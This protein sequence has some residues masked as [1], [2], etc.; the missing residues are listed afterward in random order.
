MT[1]AVNRQSAERS[2][3][4]RQRK[5]GYTVWILQRIVLKVA[6]GRW[7]GGFSDLAKMDEKVEI[8]FRKMLL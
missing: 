2:F 8:D 4:M 3:E 5:V 1:L 6:R 7:A